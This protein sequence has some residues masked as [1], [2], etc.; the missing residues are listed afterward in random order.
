MSTNSAFGPLLGF[1]LASSCP[2]LSH[3]KVSKCLRGDGSPWNEWLLPASILSFALSSTP[4]PFLCRILFSQ[5]LACKQILFFYAF[6]FVLCISLFGG[7]VRRIE[8]SAGNSG[9]VTLPWPE[10]ESPCN[11]IKQNQRKPPAKAERWK[12]EAAP[13]SPSPKTLWLSV[14]KGART[15]FRQFRIPESPLPVSVISKGS[16][17]HWSGSCVGILNHKWYGGNILKRH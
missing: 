11:A 3:L 16:I 12:N 9:P 5:A 1:V 8:L 4:T 17:R 15:V 2:V 13:G 7:L 14:D 10:V 6:I